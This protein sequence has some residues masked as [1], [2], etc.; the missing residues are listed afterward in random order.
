MLLCALVVVGLA[1][2]GTLQQVRA[3]PARR[4]RSSRGEEKSRGVRRLEERAG[5][6]SELMDGGLG[7]PERARRLLLAGG[8]SI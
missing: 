1:L 8:Q 6:E 5:L 7:A 2:A 3:P 4:W